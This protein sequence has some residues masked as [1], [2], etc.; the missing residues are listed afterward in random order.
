MK[1]SAYLSVFCLSSCIRQMKTKCQCSIRRLNWIFF[2]EE[3]NFESQLGLLNSA[4]ATDIA[5]VREHTRL[6]ELAARWARAPTAHFAMGA[7][8]CARSRAAA[9]RREPAV[10]FIMLG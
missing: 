8:A 1:Q 9:S 10:E 6:G 3:R 4:L 7:R 2:T 5:W